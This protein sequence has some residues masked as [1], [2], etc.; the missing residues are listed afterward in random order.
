MIFSNP[1]DSPFAQVDLSG[2]GALSLIRNI[3]DQM[4]NQYGIHKFSPFDSLSDLIL[5]HKPG[6]GSQVEVQY[7]PLTRSSVFTKSTGS[8]YPVQ[9]ILAPMY[10]VSQVKGSNGV[11]GVRTSNY[12]YGGLKGEL[13][14]GRGLLGFAWMQTTDADSGVSV[15]TE[16]R[17]DW[18]YTGLPSKVTTTQSSASGPNQ[19]LSQVVNTYGCLDPATGAACTVAAG[20]RYFPY[21]SQSVDSRWDLNGAALPTTTTTNSFDSYGN[22]TS[23]GVS[24]S[25]GYSKTTTSTY[26]NDTTNWFLGRLLKAQVQSVTP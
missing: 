19:Q 2:N 26:S 18:P 15:K 13:G 7:Q 10:V 5:V 8:V 6:L 9:D 4:T 20:N 22:A 3:M 1:I 23:V 14:T 12:T 11:G 25:D 21:L 24:S 16:Y 17:Q